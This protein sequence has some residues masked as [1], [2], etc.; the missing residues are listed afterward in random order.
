MRICD[1][2]RSGSGHFLVEVVDFIAR[3]M[4]KAGGSALKVDDN[5]L[6]TARRAVVEHCIYGVDL[7]PLAVELAKLSLWLVTV[8]RDRP[9]SFLDSHLLCGRQPRRCRHRRELATLTGRSRE[10]MNLVEEALER[11]LPRLI[12]C[13]SGIPELDP[14]QNRGRAGEGGVTRRDEPPS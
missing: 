13:A 5:E 2:T 9:L 10:Q 1:P 14:E 4:V 11:V 12:E 3:A 8:A 6:I 7:N